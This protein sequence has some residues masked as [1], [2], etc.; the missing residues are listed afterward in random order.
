VAVWPVGPRYLDESAKDL[1]S[2]AL[3]LAARETLHMGDIVETMLRRAMEALE[4]GDARL[5]AEIQEMDDQVDDLY[6]A[7]KLYVTDVSRESLEA[8][9]SRRAVEII[10]FT[11]NLENVGDAIDKSL[12]DAALKKIKKRKMFSPE[13]MTELRRMHAYVLDTASLA[14]TV[15]MDRDVDA[16]RLLLERKDAFRALEQEGTQSHLERLRGGRPESVETS[17]LHLDIL[18]DLKRINSHLSSIAYPIL[19]AAGQLRKTRL[20]KSADKDQSQQV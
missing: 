15:F 11:T 4:T 2:V 13:G 17:A 14:L 9:E 20:K 19:D 18:R 7:I 5:C 12:L 1:P 6:E 3:S 8:G 16:A 10:T